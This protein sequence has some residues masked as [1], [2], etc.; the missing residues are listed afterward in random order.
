MLTDQ[1]ILT[2]AP[3]TAAIAVVRLAGPGVEAFLARRFLKAVPMGKCVHGLLQ[4]GDR[5]IDDA[6]A[7]RGEGWVDLNLHGGSWVVRSAMQ[8]AER[9]GFEISD[10]KCEISDLRFEISHSADGSEIWRET[11]AA[12]PLAKTESAVR[13]LLAQPAAWEK[14]PTSPAEIQAI[15]DDRSGRWLIAAPT[16][17]IIGPANVGK[18]TLANQLFG[19]ARSITANVPGTTRDWVGDIA[20]IDGLAVMLLDTPGQRATDDAIEHAA[21]AASR[22]PIGAADL[23]VVVLDSTLPLDGGLIASYLNAIF[24]ANKSDG[25]RQWNAA[26][27]HAIPTVAIDG[28]GMNELRSA[29]RRR[30]GYASMEIEGI[31]WW[32]D[33]QREKLHRLA[34]NA[35]A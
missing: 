31:R 5:V 2:T 19:Q 8:L 7:V 35:I 15:L 13:M 28:R 12:L 22:A 27:I 9:D 33:R 10:L 34:L 3:G 18:S 21:I 25:D 29:I 30:F 26:D 11:V 24:V 4:D 6:V 17:A 23:V 16:V 14:L 1:M 20:N 32:T